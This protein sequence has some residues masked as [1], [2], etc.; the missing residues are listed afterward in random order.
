KRAALAPFT[1]L[2]VGLFASVLTGCSGADESVATNED[3]VQAPLSPAPASTAATPIDTTCEEGATKASRVVIAVLDGIESC[4]V[5]ERTC[6]NGAWSDCIHV[7]ASDAA[8][9]AH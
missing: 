6:K 8:A 4:F 1:C 9:P 7:E 3:T 5:G 2:L